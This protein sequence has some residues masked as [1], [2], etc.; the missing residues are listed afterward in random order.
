MLM[1]VLSK[2]RELSLTR[3]HMTEISSLEMRTFLDVLS[4]EILTKD[5]R[6]FVR[7]HLKLYELGNVIFAL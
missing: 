2:T 1:T 7:V 4:N 3:A 6:L 5:K